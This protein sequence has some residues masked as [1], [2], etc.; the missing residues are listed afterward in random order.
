MGPGAGDVVLPHPWL[1]WEQTGRA[2]SR[3]LPAVPLRYPAAEFQLQTR[4]GVHLQ[5]FYATHLPKQPEHR[6]AGR[7]KDSTGR[8]MLSVAGTGSSC[9]QFLDTATDTRLNGRCCCQVPLQIAPNYGKRLTLGTGRTASSSILYI[10]FL[11][12]S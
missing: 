5:F 2:R 3:V 9:S 8:Q 11:L 1:L 4:V 6:A 12:S 7:E 10:I